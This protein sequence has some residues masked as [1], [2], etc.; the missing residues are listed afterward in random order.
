MGEQVLEVALGDKRS[1]VELLVEP[2][3][4]S[5]GSEVSLVSEKAEKNQEGMMGSPIQ[6]GV[7]ELEAQP[8]PDR[9][10]DVG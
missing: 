8:D 2:G 9:S 5:E 7:S 4:R 6:S 10:L 3:R 1:A